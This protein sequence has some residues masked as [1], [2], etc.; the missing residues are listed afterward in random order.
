[1]FVCTFFVTFR[2]HCFVC[3]VKSSYSILAGMQVNTTVDAMSS[4]G[5]MS[6]LFNCGMLT[7]IDM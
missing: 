6:K 2:V 7:L 5:L 4:K 3:V 1:M